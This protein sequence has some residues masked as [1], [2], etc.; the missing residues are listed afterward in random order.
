MGFPDSDRGLFHGALLKLLLH[1][2]LRGHDG[3]ADQIKKFRLQVEVDLDGG[4]AVQSVQVDGIGL[5]GLFIF[6]D[7]AG[8]GNDQMVRVKGNPVQFIP[9]RRFSFGDPP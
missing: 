5:E 1:F 8:A 3:L 6:Q 4:G 2:N 9:W 7:S